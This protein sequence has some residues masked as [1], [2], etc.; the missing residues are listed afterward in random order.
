MNQSSC[1][2]AGH[3]TKRVVPHLQR[4]GRTSRNASRGRNLP[5]YK[6][7][8]EGEPDEIVDAIPSEKLCV[9][10]STMN[11]LRRV[12][13]LEL[14]T[15]CSSLG[16]LRCIYLSKYLLIIKQ[17]PSRQAKCDTM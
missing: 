1:Q 9:G 6:W 15:L 16:T 2:V 7:Q 8:G 10:I 14:P 13:N 12:M 17:S 5:L 3:Y 11:Y 4:R